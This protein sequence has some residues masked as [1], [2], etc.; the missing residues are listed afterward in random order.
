MVSAVALWLGATSAIAQTPYPHD[1][2]TLEEVEHGI[3]DGVRL[4]LRV[5]SKSL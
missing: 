1:V 2:V 4:A 3:H 5:R